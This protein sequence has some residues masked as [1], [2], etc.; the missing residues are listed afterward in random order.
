MTNT[1]T[2]IQCVVILKETLLN[3]EFDEGFI[4]IIFSLNLNILRLVYS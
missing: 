1:D 2:V 3:D 4:L